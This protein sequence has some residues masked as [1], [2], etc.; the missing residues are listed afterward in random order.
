MSRS[1]NDQSKHDKKVGKVAQQLEKQG[2]EVKADLKDY[3]QPDT[4]GGYRPDVVGTKGGKTK[5]VEVE[6]PSSVDSTRDKNQQ[7]AF[8]KWA[9]KSKNRSF[10]REIT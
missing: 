8:K 5:V 4:I 2:Y 7:E 1:K 6:T 10:K 3:S 9:G